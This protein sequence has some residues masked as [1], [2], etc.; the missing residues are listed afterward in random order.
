MHTNNKKPPASSKTN[1]F[2]NC[3]YKDLV[4]AVSCKK[5]NLLYIGQT[6]AALQTRMSQHKY[7]CRK[8]P[9]NCAPAQHFFN[10]KDRDP[11]RDMRIY[12]L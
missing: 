5:C 12:I 9:G 3:K 7:N 4:Y 10:A 8:R 11:E 1:D 2:G 6:G